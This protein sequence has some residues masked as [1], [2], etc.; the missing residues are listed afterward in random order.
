M[1]LFFH[2]VPHFIRCALF[3]LIVPLL[4]TGCAILEE[5]DETA[6]WTGEQFLAAGHSQMAAGDWPAAIT[7]YQKMQGRYPYGR[8]AEQAHLDMAY[9]YFKNDEP[10]LTVAATNRFIQMH[11]THPN[12][13]Y[14]FYLKG[15]ALF[16]PPDSLIG[17]L[18]GENPANHDISPVREAF[19]AYRELVSRFPESRYAPDA[20]KRL[21]Y[22]INVLAVHEVDVAHYYYALGANVAAVNRARLVLETYR[23]S[24]AVEHALGI[25]IKAYARMGLVDLQAD[26]LRVLTLNYPDSEHLN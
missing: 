14:A 12:V 16:E 6:D 26:T 25:M 1:S 18:T 19:V 7:T 8:N 10:A 23:N 3:I 13:D 2:I 22:I 24:P 15:L 21:V 11:P 17:T 5:K 20:R 9:A 4:G